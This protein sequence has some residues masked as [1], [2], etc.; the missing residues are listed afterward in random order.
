[1]C[2][3]TYGDYPRLAQRVIGS[4]Q[5]N[6]SRSRYQ[7]IVGANAIGA[8]TRAYLD[9]LHTQGEIDQVIVSAENINKCPMM[10]RMFAKV[11]TE[12]IWWFD[13]DSYIKKSGAFDQWLNRAKRAPQQTSMWGKLAW[14]EHPLAFVPDM[15][16]VLAFVRSAEWYRGLPPPSWRMGGKGEFNFEGRGTGDGRWFFMTGGC[17]LARTSALRAM[18]WPDKRLIMQGEDVFLGEAMRQ[19][20]LEIANNEGRGVAVNTEERRGENR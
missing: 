16:D 19:Q 5:R 6:C 4:I 18:D 8:E 12:F 17:W 9:S 20:G 2:V 11:E 15:E 1:M 14:C 10:R 3:L 13:D 7:L